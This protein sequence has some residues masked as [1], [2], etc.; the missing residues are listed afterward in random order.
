MQEQQ[1]WIEEKA[2]EAKQS[3]VELEDGNIYHIMHIELEAPKLCSELAEYLYT[4][5]NVH[6]T[7]CWFRHKD[8]KIPKFLEGL[9][10]YQPFKWWYGSQKYILSLRT[11]CEGIDVSKIAQMYGGGGHAQAAGCSLDYHPSKLLA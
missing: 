4:N 7:V 6:L 2:K 5:N 1:K 10:E 11:N 8:N 3:L 9:S